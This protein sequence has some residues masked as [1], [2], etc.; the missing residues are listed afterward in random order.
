MSKAKSLSELAQLVAEN[1]AK[2]LALQ[3]IHKQASAQDNATAD[4]ESAQRRAD[5][6][7]QPH[8]GRA[9]PPLLGEPISAYRKRLCGEVQKHSAKWRDLPLGGV[10]SDAF[11]QIEQQIYVDCASTPPSAE[12]GT[13]R[14]I[15]KPSYGGHKIVEYVG[16]PKS[17]MS[18]FAPPVVQYVKSFINSGKE[19]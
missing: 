9:G 2:I 14:A 13:L 11:A 16:E 5:E 3:A 19:A 17:W 15:P 18:A 10:R 12:P 6:A 4:Y 1:D 8:G 7:L